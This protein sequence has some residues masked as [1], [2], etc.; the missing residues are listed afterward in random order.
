MNAINNCDL[1]NLAGSYVGRN[2]LIIMG[3]PSILKNNYDLTLINRD[4]FICFLES[5]ALT[6]RFLHYGINPDYYL[7]F[8][9]EKARTNTLQ[10]QFIQALSCDFDLGP[11]LNDEY[12]TEWTDFCT[13]FGEYADNWRIEYLH[14][15]YRIKRDIILKNSPLSLIGKLPNMVLLCNNKAYENDGIA[16]IN[17][18]NKIMKYSLN[19]MVFTNNLDKY[20]NPEIDRHELIINYMGSINSSAIAL[21]PILKFMGFSKIYFIGMDMSLLGSLEYSSLYTF[22][23]MKLFHKFFNT[24]RQTYSY[25]FPRG[26][27]KGLFHFSST[28]LKEVST[29]NIKN[30]LSLK[31]YENLTYDLFG[32]KGKYM[33]DRKQFTECSLLFNHC[34]DIEFVNVYESFK[35]ALPIPGIKNISYEEFL[36]S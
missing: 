33:R 20:F 26:F 5:K 19:D 24:A 32:L 17:L 9:P 21:Y 27:N 34:T 36:L 15:K 23:S 12:T 14:K 10:N 29:L 7:M 4:N 18:N 1:I 28:L 3:G 11:C 35:Y 31:K 30:I 25:R 6:P 8:S 16:D 2:A 13:N 22:K